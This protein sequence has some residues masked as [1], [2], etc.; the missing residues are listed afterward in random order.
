MSDCSAKEFVSAFVVLADQD[1]IALD[2]I[3]MDRGHEVPE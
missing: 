1:L 2:K 3:P